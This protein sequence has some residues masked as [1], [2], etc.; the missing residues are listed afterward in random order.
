MRWVSCD[1]TNRKDSMRD[2]LEL[3]RLPLL[4]PEVRKCGVERKFFLIL[5]ECP[6]QN[7]LVCTGSLASFYSVLRP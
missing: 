5:I 6:T 1:S 7:G 4:S 2:L 3:V